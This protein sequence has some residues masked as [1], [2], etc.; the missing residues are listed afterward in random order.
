MREGVGEPAQAPVARCRARGLDFG[1]RPC[2]LE[3][4]A[5]RHRDIDDRVGVGCG[6]FRAINVRSMHISRQDPATWPC[7]ARSGHAARW[8]VGQAAM[9]VAPRRAVLPE[10]SDLPMGKS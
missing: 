7:V 10:E 3:Y 4:T 8:R 6:R 9:L 1:E 5:A 2:R